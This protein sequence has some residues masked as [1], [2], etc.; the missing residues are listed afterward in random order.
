[1]T[2]RMRP[3]RPATVLLLAAV[4]TVTAMTGCTAG[5]GESRPGSSATRIT[6]TSPERLPTKPADVQQSTDLHDE[7]PASW[8]RYE[9]VS[10][11]SIR[12]Y[13]TQGDPKCYGVRATV[14]EDTTTVRISLYFGTIPGAPNVCTAVGMLASLLLTTRDPIG[15]RSVIPG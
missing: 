10:D 12:I 4:L 11:H 13:F 8:S 9:I 15:T 14:E 5:Q 6:P 3:H 7:R 1:M 2:D